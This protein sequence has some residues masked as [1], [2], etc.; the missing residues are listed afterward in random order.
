MEV[1]VVIVIV[2][3]LAS[4]ALMKF[5]ETVE[6][7]RYRTHKNNLIQLKGKLMEYRYKNKNLP[8]GPRNLAQLNSALGT[9]IE[10]A[11]FTYN[12]IKWN[13]ENFRIQTSHGA[14]NYTC[15]MQGD[16]SYPQCSGDVPE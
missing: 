6:I 5:R 9:Y 7:Q 12:Y 11:D 2:G 8:N 16:F 13:I 3:V 15:T 1:M 10:D 14:P 4:L